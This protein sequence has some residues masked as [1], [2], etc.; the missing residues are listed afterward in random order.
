MRMH[1]IEVLALQQRSQAKDRMNIE[2]IQEREFNLRFDSGATP[3]Y[4]DDI[5]TEMAE[6]L[7]QFDDVGLAATKLEW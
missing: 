7:G 6:H 3:A 2:R 1:D 5:M 4:D